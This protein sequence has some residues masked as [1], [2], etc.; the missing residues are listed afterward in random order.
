MLNNIPTEMHFYRQWVV[1]RYEETDGEKPTKVPYNP[2]TGRH[3]SVSDP[4]TWVDFHTAVRALDSGNY[5]GIGFVLTRDDPYCFID[6]DDAWQKHPSGANKYADPQK[7]YERQQKVYTEFN[8]YAE[9][10]PSGKGLHL[11]CRGELSRGRKREAIEVYTSDRFMTMTGNIYR[12]A[13]ITDGH[14]PMLDL[15]WQQLGGAAVISQFE[16]GPEKDSDATLLERATNAENGFKFKQLWEGDWTGLYGSQSEADFAL[17]DIVAFYTDNREQIRRMFLDSALGQRPKAKRKDYQD[18]M[19]NRAFDRKLPPIDNEFLKLAFDEKFNTSEPGNKA[20]ADLAP[21]SASPKEGNTGSAPNTSTMLAPGYTPSPDGV[22]SQIPRPP[23]LVGM[24]ADFIYD[25]SPRPVREIALVGALGF[26]AG[27]IGRTYNISGTGLNGYF[28]LIADTGTGKEAINHGISKIVTACKGGLPAIGDFIGPSEIRSDA[29]L[30]KALGR[31][32]CFVSIA[33]EFGLRLKQLSDE[34]AGPHEIGLRR[35][36]LDL[37]AKSGQG[38]I[39]NPMIYSDKEKNTPAVMSPAFSLIGE[40]TGER[41]YEA[42]SENMV[43]EGLLPRFTSIEYTGPRPAWSQHAERVVPSF[44]LVDMITQLGARCN[45]TMVEQSHCNV[46]IDYQA[47]SISHEFNRFCDGEINGAN[48]DLIRQLW[49]RA[50]L[51]ALK[52]AAIVAVGENFNNPIITAPCMHWAINIVVRD[53]YNLISKFHSGVIGSPHAQDE[54]GQVREV[55][56][57]LIDWFTNPNSKAASYGMSSK[58]VTMR[59]A[60]YSSISRRTASTAVFRRDKRGANKALKDTLQHMVETGLLVPMSK[61]DH[62]KIFESE[63]LAYMVA[64]PDVLALKAEG[65][66]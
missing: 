51:K 1:W 61:V 2:T 66:I 28:M 15:L 24:I 53:I 41:F 9:L 46:G 35:V 63:A 40:S 5:S 18:Y 60:L 33:G 21:G 57:A 8:T 12:P 64:N 29:A 23:G 48:R 20:P 27:M 31:T 13:G 45:E 7:V 52:L 19:I 42:L 55:S 39:L 26:M 58:H 37:F 59:I 49:N 65:K 14:Q 62:A 4:H 34:R 22:N 6:L 32:P 10:S 50:H 38:N 16:G 56:R 43:T 36:L 54:L 47:D 17:V 44:D 30:L 3:A 11:I 25:Q